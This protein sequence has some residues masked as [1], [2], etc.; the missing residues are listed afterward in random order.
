MHKLWRAELVTLLM[1]SHNHRRDW[2][3]LRFQR[4][5]SV[6]A[7]EAQQQRAAMVAGAEAEVSYQEAQ[8]HLLVTCAK[9]SKDLHGLIKA[10]LAEEVEGIQVLNVMDLLLLFT[11]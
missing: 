11:V 7:G 8:S 6:V 3:G 10:L 1:P 5:K 2:L 9:F 4:A